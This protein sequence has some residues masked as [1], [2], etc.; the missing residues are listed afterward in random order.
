[1]K[2]I[3]IYILSIFLYLPVVAAQELITLD[4]VITY[5][6]FSNVSYSIQ[7]GMLP[8]N[9]PGKQKVLLIEFSQEPD[10]IKKED[11]NAVALFKIPQSSEPTEI[12][13]RSTILLH[14]YD[15][16]NAAS[17][18]QYLFPKGTLDEFLKHEKN[19]QVNHKKIQTKAAEIKGN[20]EEEIIR[21]IHDFVVGHM[22]YTNNLSETRGAK[23]SLSSGKGDCTEYSELMVTLCRAKGI[24]ARI[25][26]GLV[27]VNYNKNPRHNW[28]EV[29]FEKLGWVPFDPTFSDCGR[30]DCL[31]NFENLSGER[32]YFSYDRH[33][34][35]N[36]INTSIRSN[37]WLPVNYTF[38]TQNILAENYKEAHSLFDSD[39]YE[40]SLVLLDSFINMG[41]HKLNYHHLKARILCYQGRLNEAEKDILMVEKKSKTPYEKGQFYLLKA[42]W[43]A[44][45]KDDNN[46][47]ASLNKW[48]ESIENKPFGFYSLKHEKAFTSISTQPEFK[49]L[50]KSNEHFY[51]TNLAGIGHLQMG[52]PPCFGLNTIQVAHNPIPILDIITS[53][54]VKQNGI[55]SITQ[56]KYQNITRTSEY[57]K[58]GNLLMSLFKYSGTEYTY[59]ALNRRTSLHRFRHKDKKVTS[60]SKYFYTYH[61]KNLKSISF[62]K[63]NC[64]KE[65]AILLYEFELLENNQWKIS[66][67]DEY[68]NLKDWSVFHFD[69][70]NRI[71]KIQGT[72]LNEL[73][74]IDYQYDDEKLKLEKWLI[75]QDTSI[76]LSSV[77]LTSNGNYS[78]SQLHFTLPYQGLTKSTYEY[79]KK[80]RLTT[81][82]S[83]VVSEH[84]GKEITHESIYSY[85]YNRKGMRKKTKIKRINYF[86]SGKNK[87][88]SE[89]IYSYEF[90]D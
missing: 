44:S 49:K 83:R 58:N 4:Q 6:S 81:S 76:H 72:H 70:L 74:T 17:S 66:E 15:F 3:I 63:G 9:I 29:Y 22:N 2:N 25:V 82:T 61:E 24:P 16:K 43:Y 1:M 20:T 60:S 40:A 68:G 34:P 59:D 62:C 10:E 19:F 32:I 46:T 57:D 50:L 86:E 41:F 35:L 12:V 56:S 27:D 5:P 85:F 36:N 75:T 64:E 48:K 23:K 87:T 47:Y 31:N 67:L 13:I 7:K 78:S 89:T 69:D 84:K 53:K 80:E 52:D 38:S 14:P 30:E 77:E 33:I 90:W 88:L 54:I 26:M 18:K 79:D 21:N 71:K 28:V 37:Y 8:R 45:K 42:I 73:A 39:Q 11:G 51:Y 65:N 55:K